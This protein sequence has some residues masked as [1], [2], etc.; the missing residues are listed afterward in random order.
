MSDCFWEGFD[1]F[2]SGHDINQNPYP[3]DAPE[4]EEWRDGWLAGDMD[5]NL[6]EEDDTRPW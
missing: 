4:H 6:N 3:E 5:Q 2:K 1:A